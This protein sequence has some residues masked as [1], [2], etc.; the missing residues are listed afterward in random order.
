[1]KIFN[2]FIEMPDDFEV[3]KCD[4]CQYSKGTDQCKLIGLITNGTCL[5]NCHCPLKV[6]Q[7]P[8]LSPTQ[9]YALDLAKKHGGLKRYK[10]SSYWIGTDIDESQIKQNTHSVYPSNVENVGTH[11]INALI[12]LGKLAKINKDLVQ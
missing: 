1:M 4:K 2:M 11:S 7:Q 5:L 10:K 8:K 3:G 12:R 9:E 6:S